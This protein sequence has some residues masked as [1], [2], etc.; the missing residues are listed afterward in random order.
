[1]GAHVT[2][3]ALVIAKMIVA[4]LG[5]LFLLCPATLFEGRLSQSKRGTL[6]RRIFVGLGVLGTLS[7]FAEPLL[8][9]PQDSTFTTVRWFHAWDTYHY[10][11]GAK[12]FE[13]LGYTDLYNATA[14]ADAE[15]GYREPGRQRWVRNLKTNELEPVEVILESAEDYKGL[16][17]AARW[18]EFRQDIDYFRDVIKPRTAPWSYVQLDH[19]YNAT[20]AWNL[21]GSLVANTGPITSW[22]IALLMS[23]DFVLLSIM[24]WMVWRTFGL[25]VCC[26]CLLFWGTSQPSAYAW[27]SASLL[28]FDWLFWSICG[29]CSLKQGHFFRSGFFLA[30]ATLLRIF[31]GVM[32]GALGLKVLI[33]FI[34]EREFRVP[35]HTRQFALGALVAVCLLIPLATLASGRGWSVWE[36]F[37]TNSAKHIGSPAANTL[38]LKS[39]LSYGPESAWVNVAKRTDATPTETLW[40]EERKRVFE[41]RE[42]V[43]LLATLGFVGLLGFSVRHIEWWKAAVL[44][45]GL[46]AFAFSLSG[47]YYVVFL[48]FGFLYTQKRIVGVALCALA[49]LSNLAL[50][51][52]SGGELTYLDTSLAAIAFIVMVTCLFVRQPAPSIPDSL[53]TR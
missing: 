27:T 19:G 2:T 46:I 29:V 4:L 17:S 48:A 39:V 36:E 30:Y 44:G 21:L 51:V 45:L 42:S 53:V 9:Q 10:Y 11:V 16:F 24:W 15:S 33:D 18:L 52:Y 6:R 32:I 50:L 40:K 37:Y 47:Y 7:W 34:R 13:E 5:M 3:D 49:A 23:I 41:R 25:E 28:R 31:P 1:V 26:V 38:G 35:A 12:Y 8:H 20:P 43:F 14:V 22:K